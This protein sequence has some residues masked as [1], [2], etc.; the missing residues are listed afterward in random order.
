MGLAYFPGG[1]GTMD[2][3]FE[4]LTLMQTGKMPRVPI[5]LVGERAYWNK[6]LSFGEF[7][8]Q[9]LISRADLKLFTFAEDAEQAWTAIESFAR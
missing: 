8:R 3:L 6:V 9:G 5:V 2:E 4:V 1:F 7:A